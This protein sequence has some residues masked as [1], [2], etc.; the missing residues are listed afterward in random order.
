M[1]N[2]GIIGPGSIAN[3]FATALAACPRGQLYAVASRDKQRAQDFIEKYQGQVAYDSYQALIDDPKV[4]VIYLATPHSHHYRVA[5]A[6]LSAGKHL[7]ME[8]PLTVNAQQAEQLVKLSQQH[9]CVFQEALWSRFMPCFAQVKQWLDEGQIGRLQYITSQIGFAFDG[10]PDHRLNNPDLAGGALLD[11]GVYST[12]LS[13]FL[14]S[15]DPIEVQAMSRFNT[16]GV[17]H[18]TQ[19]N[20]RYRSGVLSQFTCTIGAQ[21]SNTMTIHGDKGFIEIPGMFWVG[22]S[23]TLRRPEETP[24]EKGFPHKVNGFEYQID[25]TMTLIEN[26]QLFDPR[27]SHQDSV[28]VMHTLDRIRETI[29]LRYHPDI[30]AL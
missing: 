13:Q 4:D 22:Q 10:R 28:E 16:Q 24:I 25:A 17:D 7:L 2:W 3:T 21:C 15:E 9:Q 27:M 26:N 20:L 29:G 5:K 6:I 30:E 1:L 18:N 19:V 12:S 8:K 14:L 11:L 23:A